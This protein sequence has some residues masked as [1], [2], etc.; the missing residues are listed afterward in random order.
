[1]TRKTANKMKEEEKRRKEKRIDNKKQSKT[2][3][4]GKDQQGIEVNKRN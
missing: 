3:L 1:M 2:D 4:V